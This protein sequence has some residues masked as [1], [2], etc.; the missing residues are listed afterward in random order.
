MPEAP[1]A[2]DLTGF[3][4]V[5]VPTR[6]GG[7]NLLDGPRGDMTDRFQYGQ[8][9]LSVHPRAVLLSPEQGQ[10]S[11]LAVFLGDRVGERRIIHVDLDAF[12]PSVEEILD[13]SIAGLP[14]LVGGDPRGRGVVSSAS[15]PARAY[16]VRSA[17][18]MAVALRLCPNALVVRGHYKA[19]S[20]YSKRVMDILSEYTPLWEPVSIDEAFLDV[21]GCEQ[22]W[23]TPEGI[24]RLIQK[25]IE[26]E[27]GLSAS[28]GLAS[29]KLVAKIASGL[30]KPHGFVC[31]RQG[32]EAAFLA[33]L[34]VEKLWGVGQVTGGAL[35]DMGIQT[36]GELAELPLRLLMAK[37]G[38]QGAWLHEHVR[39]IDRS[40]VKTEHDPKSV[41]HER[42]FRRDV[43]DVDYILRCLLNLSEMTA[44]RLRKRGL[45]A[46]VVV[47]KLRYND[48]RTVTRRV[49][50]DEPTDLAEVLHAKVSDL[51]KKE[52]KAGARVR[53]VGVGASGLTE[54]GYQLSLFGQDD[55]RLHRLSEA[56]DRIRGRYGA[57]AIKRASLLDRKRDR[58]DEKS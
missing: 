27:V 11:R 19:Y 6:R 23:G 14:I 29:N 22:L 26:D 32:E 47:L 3:G 58:G 16:G 46:R 34:S 48:F 53:L 30:R 31:V 40:P 20:E 51:L 21:T 49:T 18:P 17:M 24:G 4:R 38:Q 36:I 57:D 9:P 10:G 35:R 25:R 54:G 5:D 55:A 2:F 13:P 15:Y 1:S 44:A 28:V 33:P 42:T 12:Y 8:L 56:V 52:L 41:S 39:G 7:P 43:D 50:L 45:R 37:L